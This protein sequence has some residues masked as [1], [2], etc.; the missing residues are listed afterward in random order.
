MSSEEGVRGPS[1]YSLRK[2]CSARHVLSSGK[3]KMVQKAEVCAPFTYT[4]FL[5][6]W[7]NVLGLSWVDQGCQSLPSEEMGRGR[8]GFWFDGSPLRT[9]QGSRGFRAEV[10]GT[11]VSMSPSCS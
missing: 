9:R 4:C 3:E 2:H 10:A 5:M 7:Q 1:D 8:V 11:L 6:F